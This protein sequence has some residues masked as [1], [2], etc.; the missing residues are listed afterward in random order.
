MFEATNHGSVLCWVRLGRCV[1]ANG[2]GCVCC[3]FKLILLVL[4]IRSTKKLPSDDESTNTALPEPEITSY[5]Y[6]SEDVQTRVT[7]GL[8]NCRRHAE[9]LSKVAGNYRATARTQILLS[10]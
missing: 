4:L 5:R 7:I 9:S 3:C 10:D 8:I 1:M 2:H 6:F